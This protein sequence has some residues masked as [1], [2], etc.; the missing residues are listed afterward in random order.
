MPPLVAHA[1]HVILDL[2]LYLGPVLAI[3]IAVLVA[4][5]KARKQ[6]GD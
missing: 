5:L 4:N 6:S 1:G 3:G 2:V